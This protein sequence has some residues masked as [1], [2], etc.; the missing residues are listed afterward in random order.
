MNWKNGVRNF[1][2]YSALT[3]GIIGCSN[4]ITPNVTTKQGSNPQTLIGYRLDVFGNRLC[5]ASKPHCL[6]DI[7]GW[8]RFNIDSEK[9]SGDD[10]WKSPFFTLKDKK[11]DCEDVALMNVYFLEKLG[12]EP[13]LLLIGTNHEVGKKKAH[14]V[15]LFEEEKGG[16]V[17][18]GYLEK[19][20]GVFAEHDSVKSLLDNMN[21]LQKLEGDDKY[22][23]YE[24][25]DLNSWNVDWRT[26]KGNL[27]DVYEQVTKKQEKK[28]FL[29]SFF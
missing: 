21:T 12:Y 16:K 23:D 5:M 26:Y 11:G 3:L 25:V 14:A 17:H 6:S 2:V 29:F 9:D 27:K 4:N 13:R 22:V 24:I 28:S 15:A 19:I 10:Y 18:Y 20:Y 7:L 8:A 1:L